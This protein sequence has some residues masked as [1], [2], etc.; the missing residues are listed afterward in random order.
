MFTLTTALRARFAQVLVQLVNFVISLAEFTIR[1]LIAVVALLW[2]FLNNSTANNFLLRGNA[3]VVRYEEIINI[4]LGD[5]PDSLLNCLCY[6]LNYG[7]QIPP[8]TLDNN[9]NFVQCDSPVCVPVNFIPP[10]PVLK[11]LGELEHIVDWSNGYLD[12]SFARAMK[13][14]VTPILAYDTEKDL[15]HTWYHPTFFRERFLSGT[16]NL[17]ASKY[18]PASIQDVDALIARKTQE[19]HAKQDALDQCQRDDLYKSR[20]RIDDPWRYKLLFAQNKLPDTSHCLKFGAYDHI[21][22]T[23]TSDSREQRAIFLSSARR[24]NAYG[25]YGLA[26]LTPMDIDE[27]WSASGVNLT[28]VEALQAREWYSTVTSP[29]PPPQSAVAAAAFIPLEERI[30]DPPPP[31]TTRPTSPP[32]AGCPGPG[33]PPNPCFDLCCFGRQI[34][35][36][37]GTALLLAGHLL[38]GLIRGNFPDTANGEVKWGYFIGSNC[39]A[40][41]L[42]KDIMNLIVYALN[43]LVCLCKLVTL[44]LPSSPSFPQPDFCCALTKAADLIVNLLQ[45]L[46]NGIKSLVLDSPRFIYFNDGYMSRDV[47]EI[48]DELLSISACLCQFLRYIFPIS[49]LTGG[50]LANGGGAFDICCIPQTIVDSIIQLLRLVI[51]MIINIATLEGAGSKFWFKVCPREARFYL[52]LCLT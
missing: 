41:C 48:F 21:N 35:Q 47:N 36:T 13:S 16:A 40:R 43:G 42:E 26:P 11:R 31:L 25:A 27:Y 19:F 8:I 39:G 7:I 32:I 29:P 34:I 1:M 4:L 51:L 45:M 14:R 52:L 23:L 3:V 33:Q 17:Y 22:P 44:V 20:L 38:D 37:T 28:T 12:K 6:I 30:L 9:A 2:D 10:P 24:Y 5:T 15:N 49:Q 18:L 46:V 50:T